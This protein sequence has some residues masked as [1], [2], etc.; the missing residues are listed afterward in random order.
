MRYRLE[1]MNDATQVRMHAVTIYWLMNWP[2]GG[3]SLAHKRL[4]EEFCGTVRGTHLH[5]EALVLHLIIKAVDRVPLAR[6]Q[7]MQIPCFLQLLASGRTF[8]AGRI[9]PPL[10]VAC[11]GVGT[12]PVLLF[13]LLSFLNHVK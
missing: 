8:L 1:E 11:S 9:P 10:G 5:I 13:P 4:N 6:W 2:L 12:A 7:H 3:V